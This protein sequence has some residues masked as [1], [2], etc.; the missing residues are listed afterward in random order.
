MWVPE[1]PRDRATFGT[2]FMRRLQL[3]AAGS[4]AT[5]SACLLVAAPAYAATSDESR[6]NAA[7]TAD[8]DHRN[9]ESLAPGSPQIKSAGIPAATE[10]QARKSDIVEDDTDLQEQR[11]LYAQF[12]EKF[13]SF[14]TTV[15]TDSLH[16]DS[17]TAIADITEITTM[18]RGKDVDGTSLPD[19]SYAFPQTATLTK[20][21][22]TWQVVSVEH[23][24]TTAAIDL[25][26]TVLPGEDVLAARADGSIQA[27]MQDAL[28]AGDVPATQSEGMADLP[29]FPS[30][31]KELPASSTTIQLGVARAK[32]GPSIQLA[33]QYVGSGANRS[34][35]VAYAK[36]YA[37]QRNPNY[38][39]M[40]DDC[41][42]FVSQSLVAGGWKQ[43]YGAQDDERAWF[44][45]NIFET[46]T[47]TKAQ[48]M[49]DWGFHTAGNFKY[50]ETWTAGDIT[51]WI[52]D[53][54]TT[55]DHS[56][57][58]TYVDAQHRPYFSEHS[59][60][61]VNKSYAAIMSENPNAIHSDWAP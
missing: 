42:N 59:N 2:D 30:I 15:S 13:V 34:A 40:P 45:N 46:L 28:G 32:S 27:A 22:T 36:K 6:I 26:E 49:F 58:V 52:W 53:K 33:T 11:Q 14:S 47:W 50:T 10:S 29:M 8:I 25:P 23:D 51:F 39:S 9:A 21:G 38:K 16:L 4:A 48:S 43:I 60:D 56:T 41:T 12:G 24:E 44:G 37:L 31:E 61:H 35:I 57:V 19:Y 3:L 1:A 55:F 18:R 7:I 54:A 17:N 20:T 5:L